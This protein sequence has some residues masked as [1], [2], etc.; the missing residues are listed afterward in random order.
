MARRGLGVGDPCPHHRGC[1]NEA[2]AQPGPPLPI[3]I[4]V[5]PHQEDHRGGEV[6]DY[7]FDQDEVLLG[8]SEAVDLRLPHKAVSL[9][10]GRLLRE[11]G[12]LRYSDLNS[13]NGSLVDGHP[14]GSGQSRDVDVGSRL[15]IGPFEVCLVSP[16]GLTGRARDRDTAS[17]ARQMVVDLLHALGGESTPTLEWTSGP[18]RGR[19][20]ELSAGSTT[21]LGRSDD[22]EVCLRDADASRKHAEI[23]CTLKGVSIADLGS[24]NGV[25]VND[26]RIEGP[27]TLCD[28]D[29]IRIGETELRY[30]D[31]AE[32]VL[33]DLLQDGDE[34]SA[35]RPSAPGATPNGLP[36]RQPSRSGEL[37]SPAHK[38]ESLSPSSALEMGGDVSVV[39]QSQVESEGEPAISSSRRTDLMLVVVGGF[40]VLGA[41]AL[42]AYLLL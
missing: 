39:P 2:L 17:Y 25:R 8:R 26:K 13:T 41:V 19:R 24:K 38:D 10:H 9:V 6:F 4:T 18:D 33:A 27:A 16:D 31:P 37:R 42:I 5:S 14:V 29:R 30:V 40:V 15:V 22:C 7:Q 28:G 1:D 34:V 23:R 12:Q 20:Y 32:E 3:Y 35:Q 21:T 36:D 11:D